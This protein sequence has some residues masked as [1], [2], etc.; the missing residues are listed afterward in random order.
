MYCSKCG[1]ENADTSRF[2][3]FC[4][5][6]LTPVQPQNTQPAAQ[7]V[8]Q[9]VQQPVAQPYNP[10]QGA[11]NII[12]QQPSDPKKNKNNKKIGIIIGVVAAVLMFIISFVTAK[13][14]TEKAFNN[15]VDGNDAV[16]ESVQGEDAGNQF[17]FDALPEV[18]ALD[19]HSFTKSDSYGN[20]A[21]YEYYCKGDEV[22]NITQSAV[23]I[24]KGADKDAVDDFLDVV[25]DNKEKYSKYDCVKYTVEIKDTEITEKLEIKNVSDNIDDLR[26]LGLIQGIGNITYVS[27]KQTEEALVDAGF[28]KN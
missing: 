14:A 11:G 9:P 23:T 17:T 6:E 19:C 16:V 5:S 7:P 8:Q 27:I 28:T 20:S 15:A 22:V 4:G 1:K 2:C 13:N 3:N 10:T 21:V 25:E 24:T 26:T 18:T 12:I